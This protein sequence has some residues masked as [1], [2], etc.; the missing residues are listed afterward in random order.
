MGRLY[1]GNLAAYKDVIK[2][3]KEDHDVDVVA[4]TYR[5]EDYALCRWVAGE[6]L[7]VVLR[8][9]VELTSKRFE[10]DDEDVRC[11][12]QTEWL[13]KVHSDLKHWK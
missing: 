2:R 3:L 12:A 1:S 13:R 11:N 4:E 8:N 10:Q 5:R 9:G 7:R 6:T